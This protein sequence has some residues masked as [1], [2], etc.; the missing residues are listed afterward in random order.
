MDKLADRPPYV[1]FEM[2]PMEDRA[3]SILKGVTCYKDVPFVLVTPAGSK[4]VFEAVASEWFEMME[5]EAGRGRVPLAW[6]QQFKVAF[7][8][9]Q[10]GEEVPINGTPLNHW[11]SLTKGHYQLLRSLGIHTIEDVAAMNEEAMARI[12]MGA[13]NLKERARMHLE[14]KDSSAA[15]A[16][17]LAAER[18]KTEAQAAQL[19]RMQEQLDALMAE[20]S[21]GKM[22][23]PAPAPAP[24]PVPGSTAASLLDDTPL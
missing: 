9:W 24:T 5:K 20:Q 8:A 4:D 2:R 18:A 7:K 12:G 13:R 11:P 1:R 22:P 16:E 19:A 23:G 21:R 6:F 10:E 15:V 3:Q 17:Q 14:A